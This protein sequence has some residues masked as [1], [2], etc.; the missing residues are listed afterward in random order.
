MLAL[1]FNRKTAFGVLFISLFVSM[2]GLGVISPLMSIYAESIG[3][4]GLWLGAI[5][6]G[7]NLSRAFIMPMVGKLSD[8]WR[9]RKIFLV[10]GMVFYGLASIGY[11]LSKNAIHLFFARFLQGFGA[12]MVLPISLA[13][14]GDISPKGRE[15]TY[16]GFIN[17]ARTLG[18][19]CGPLIGGFLMDLYGF[20]IPFIIMGGLAFASLTLIIFALP[21]S[22]KSLE[23][24][25]NVS[26]RKILEVKT[27]RAV[28]LYRAINAIGTGN[29]FTFFPLLADSIGVAP[30]EVGILLSSRILVLSLLQGP[31]GVLAD[32]FDK[33][34]LILLSGASS[35]G[36]LLL[37]PLTTSFLEMLIVGLLLGCTWAVLM[38]AT[39][40]LAAEYG[41]ELGMASVMSTVNLG[42]SVGMI[43]GPLTSGLIMD[44]L[45]LHSVFYIGGLIAVFGT[46]LFYLHVRRNKNS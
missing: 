30:T 4:T 27:I 1:N 5:F 23:H 25:T 26:Y 13:Y 2:L 3:A 7:F 45:N 33:T 46:S 10:I 6:S 38:P 18:W 29:L 11:V 15:G 31:C 40:S 28:V 12:G 9:R 16:T 44:F 24:R 14:I 43:I 34:M 8:A 42:M 22:K 39:T 37:V 19:G 17:V 36:L 21:E 35:A 32:K 20:A 41:R